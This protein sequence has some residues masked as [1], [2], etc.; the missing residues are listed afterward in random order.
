MSAFLL[1]LL[2]LTAF[3]PAPAHARPWLCLPPAFDQGRRLHPLPNPD[4]YWL[5]IMLRQH[6]LCWRAPR[7]PNELRVLLLGSSAVYGFPLP[8]EETLSGYLN[9]HFARTGTPAH[10]FNLGFVT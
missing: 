5:E 1:L 10:M 8:V 2:V 7:T 3:M 9:D 6:E 4:V